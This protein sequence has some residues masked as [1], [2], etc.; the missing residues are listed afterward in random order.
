LLHYNA[1]FGPWQH[2]EGTILW[3]S[4]TGTSAGKS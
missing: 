2:G 1:D 3:Q 4:K